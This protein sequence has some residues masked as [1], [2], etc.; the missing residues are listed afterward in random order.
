MRIDISAYFRG[1]LAA[2]AI[3]ELKRKT[4]KQT[5]QRLKVKIL[6]T[7]ICMACLKI[8][9]FIFPMRYPDISYYM[10]LTNLLPLVIIPAYSLSALD[11]SIAYYYK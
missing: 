6:H 9:T 2:V 4:V 7:Y 3:H 10:S 8:L 1:F 5:F 11:I